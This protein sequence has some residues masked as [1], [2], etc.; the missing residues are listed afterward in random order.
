MSVKETTSILTNNRPLLL[1]ACLLLAYDHN[2]EPTILTTQHTVVKLKNYSYFKLQKCTLQWIGKGKCNFISL[3]DK[4]QFNSYEEKSKLYV[5]HPIAIVSYLT[6]NGIYFLCNL[7][8]TNKSWCLKTVLK[9]FANNKLQ[10]Q[11]NKLLFHIQKTHHLE[12]IH[13]T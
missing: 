8:C 2:V 10:P 4:I 13:R 9:I 7:A 1:Y 6:F 5:C 12:Y 3:S 11:G